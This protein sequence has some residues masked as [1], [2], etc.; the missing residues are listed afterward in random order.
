MYKKIVLN[1]ISAF[2]FVWQTLCSGELQIEGGVTAKDVRFPHYSELL[3]I[4]CSDIRCQHAVQFLFGNKKW[5]CPLIFQIDHHELLSTPSYILGTAHY[6]PLSVLG[7][8]FNQ[9]LKITNFLIVESIDQEKRINRSLFEKLNVLNSSP[10][11]Y[12]NFLDSLTYKQKIIFETSIL[13]LF[14]IY[15]IKDI[16]PYELFSPFILCF[17]HQLYHVGMDDD[18]KSLIEGLHRPVYGLENLEESLPNCIPFLPKNWMTDLNTLVSL[19]SQSG[20]SF[21]EHFC[22]FAFPILNG[23]YN[24]ISDYI[25]YGTI[26]RNQNWTP[27]LSSLL[28]NNKNESGL[29]VVGCAHLMGEDSLQSLLQNAGFSVSY[30]GNNF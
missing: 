15:S 3:L 23:E 22:S 11:D 9:I 17:Y 18:I 21:A 7:E 6:L 20:L 12:D 10:E 27:V 19:R 24:Q 13:N 1:F 16:Q 14:Q 29:I 26:T 30:I 25:T 28:S 2:F 5:D 4:D 8:K